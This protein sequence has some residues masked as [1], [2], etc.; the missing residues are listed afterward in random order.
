MAPVLRHRTLN[1]YV[2]PDAY[3]GPLLSS[4]GS[5]RREDGQRPGSAH[6]TR[7]RGRAA[8]SSPSLA[9]PA[10][11]STSADPWPSLQRLPQ[12]FEPV[13][14]AD[15]PGKT[16][17][18]GAGLA[19][20]VLVLDRLT[21]SISLNRA[22]R[23]PARPRCLI[24]ISKLTAACRSSCS[25]EPGDP[26]R[27]RG[28]PHRLWHPRHRPARADGPP[29]PHQDAR[30]A[31]AALPRARRPLA[32]VLPDPAPCA[33][34]GSDAFGAR[35]PAAGPSPARARLDAA[36]VLVLVRP[37]E[38][39]PA[40]ARRRRRRRALLLEFCHDAPARRRRR[41]R[42]EGLGCP[43]RRGVGRQRESPSSCL[44]NERAR[45]CGAVDVSALTDAGS[46]SRISAGIVRL[47]GHLRLCVLPFRSSPG[48]STH[49]DDP[50]CS[51]LLAPASVRPAL[52]LAPVDAAL[53]PPTHLAPVA[54]PPGHA[55]QPAGHRRRRPRGQLRRDGADRRRGRA[56]ADRRQREGGRARPGKRAQQRRRGQGQVQL[57]PDP[58]ERARLLGPDQQPSLRAGPARDGPAVD[59]ASCPPVLSSLARGEDDR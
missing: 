17:E 49:T 23:P 14:Q 59:G 50:S 13:D 7:S 33:V 27:A 58:R 37:D 15:G 12:V 38:L 34:V 10:H 5:L 41:Q 43:R 57:R 21:G 56:P 55:L 44:G 32:L 31:L 16:A 42:Q 6:A 9:R 4:S 30:A 28:G 52:G 18:A 26:T 11:G 3:V 1:V 54:P 36:L 29:R 40:P 51:P 2:S 24:P 46:L 25:A 53:P 8:G 20:D 45:A 39:A 19:K 35:G 47:A 48:S 22:C